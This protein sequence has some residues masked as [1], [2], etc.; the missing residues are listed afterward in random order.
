MGDLRG[1]LV[2]EYNLTIVIGNEENEQCK[3]SSNKRVVLVISK[4]FPI[5]DNFKCSNFSIFGQI[6]RL[7]LEYKDCL[8]TFDKF[9]VIFLK[10]PKNFN[11]NVKICNE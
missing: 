7:E 3:G 11:K 2:N 8:F 4:Y 6:R 10:F 1:I 5:Y 9:I